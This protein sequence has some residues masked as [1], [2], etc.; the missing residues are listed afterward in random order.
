MGYLDA[1][2]RPDVSVFFLFWTRS[3]IAIIL[4]SM[5]NVYSEPNELCDR[6]NIEG[7][8]Q[9]FLHDFTG[10]TRAGIANVMH[11]IMAKAEMSGEKITELDFKKGIEQ[12]ENL[13]RRVR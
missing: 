6:E 12:A 9:S 4:V 2:F 13:Y 5:A 3:Y 8:I 10:G 1:V 11:G 7:Y